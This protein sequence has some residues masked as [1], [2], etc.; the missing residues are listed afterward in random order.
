[1]TSI[2]D[3]TRLYAFLDEH[4]I[5]YQRW[6]HPAVFTVEQVD[7][8]AIEFPGYHT[9]NLFLRDKR[10]TRLILLVVR[11]DKTIQLKQAA[12][13]IGVHHLS[14]ASEQRLQANLGIGA[15]SVSIFALLNDPERR[16]ECV[17]DRDVWEAHAITAHP[18]INTSTLVISHNDL[19]TF[20]SLTGH[21][22]QVI[23]L[24]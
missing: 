23:D 1:M 21:A 2:D 8:L 4:N 3:S 18:L 19:E 5:Y 9:K 10:A 15:G 17:F 20:L 24:P 11:G 7:Q 14:F 22:V 13:L 6:D 12:D 16:V